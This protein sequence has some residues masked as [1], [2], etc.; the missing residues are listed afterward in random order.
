M[1]VSARKPTYE[2]TRAGAQQEKHQHT[3][4]MNLLTEYTSSIEKKISSIEQ[5]LKIYNFLSN[6]YTLLQ[7]E[8]HKVDIQDSIIESLREP[9]YSKN[10]ET[11]SRRL[12]N[13]KLIEI[14]S[15]IM[16][17]DI[18]QQYAISLKQ[19]SI[20]IESLKP[21]FAFYKLRAK[22]NS[23]NYPFRYQMTKMYDVVKM[24]GFNNLDYTERVLLSIWDYEE[25][26]EKIQEGIAKLP[27]SSR[28]VRE[29]FKEQ[30]LITF[31]LIKLKSRIALNQLNTSFIKKYIEKINLPEGIRTIHF[32]DE[33]H[34]FVE[35]NNFENVYKEL[36]EFIKHNPEDIVA[37]H[38][39][40]KFLFENINAIVLSKNIHSIARKGMFKGN[41]EIIQN[42]ILNGVSDIDK[43]IKENNNPDYYLFYNRGFLNFLI[44]IE[45]FS[46]SD[47]DFKKAKE[48]I[49]DG[50]KIESYKE[51]INRIIEK[52]RYDRNPNYDE[53]IGPGDLGYSNLEKMIIGE[54]YGGIASEYYT[55]NEK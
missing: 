43:L 35:L 34:H 10:S 29:Y 50:K 19:I 8:E 41:D 26:L 27:S 55:D 22:L 11:R 5:N 37:I 30:K 24:F 39:R 49:K 33:F 31:E 20:C 3:K 38:F 4:K 14:H 36:S 44:E 12:K 2:N 28:E 52:D 17:E 32:H 23:L 6:I 48:I 21:N 7:N 18:I 46:D 16:S 42:Y 40:Y 15:K 9:K 25:Y 47:S 1:F 13:I 51:K 53:P 54:L 45:D